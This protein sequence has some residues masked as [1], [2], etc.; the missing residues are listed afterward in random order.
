MFNIVYL[1]RVSFK[2]ALSPQVLHSEI[3]VLAFVKFYSPNEEVKYI[4]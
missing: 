3:Q 4:D 1:A 2:M